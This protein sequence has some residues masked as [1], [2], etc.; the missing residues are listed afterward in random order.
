MDELLSHLEDAKVQYGAESH[1]A[2]MINNAWMIMDKYVWLDV[3]VDDAT[4]N[5]WP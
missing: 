5:I 4:A 1:L 3:I 2:S